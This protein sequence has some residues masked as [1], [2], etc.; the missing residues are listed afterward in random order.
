M[1][2]GFGLYCGDAQD[3]NDWGLRIGW[4][5]KVGNRVTQVYLENGS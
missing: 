4:G 3:K 2:G 1:T 5:V